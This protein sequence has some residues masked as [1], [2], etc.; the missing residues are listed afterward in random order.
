MR[1]NA[2][3]IMIDSFCADRCCSPAT[4]LLTIPVHDS[5]PR[6]AALIVNT[7]ATVVVVQRDRRIAAIMESAITVEA[8][9]RLPATAMGSS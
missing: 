4:R 6:R 1:P 3:L 9:L 7:L 8:A 2:V 5:D